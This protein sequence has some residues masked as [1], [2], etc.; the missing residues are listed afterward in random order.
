MRTTAGYNLL[1]VG[2]ALRGQLIK[3]LDGV[4]SAEHLLGIIYTLDEADDWRDP[5]AW[6]KANPM[7]GISPTLEFVEKYCA[8]AQQAPDLEG[9]FKVK[10]CSLWSHSSSAWLAMSAWDRCADETLDIERFVGKPCWM[11]GDLAQVDDLAAVALLFEEDGILYG[12]VRCYLPADVVEERA[13]AVPAYRGWVRDGLLVMTEGPMTDVD[14][15]QADIE[16]DCLR[17]DVKQVV[18]DQFGS[19]QVAARLVAKGVPAIVEPKNART[20]TPPAREL[21]ARVKHQRF[22]HDGNSC[23]RWQASNTVVDRRVD[24]SILP[25]KE[26]AESPNKIDGIDALLSSI[27]AWLRSQVKPIERDYQVIIVGGARA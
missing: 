5:K 13:R 14:Q 19:A 2:Y 15:I 25:K 27:G 18:F 17:F 10:V 11:A 12:F 7:L 21:E 4:F 16:A 1:S 9:E 20:F 8:D 6:G 22:R 3:V 24:G 26:A 23:L